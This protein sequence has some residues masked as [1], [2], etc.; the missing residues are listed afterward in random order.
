MTT[1]FLC[2]ID[3]S[4]LYK[5][6]PIGEDP[7]L[8]ENGASTSRLVEPIS[9]EETTRPYEQGDRQSAAKSWR[10]LEAQHGG[11]GIMVLTIH[12]RNNTALGP[13]RE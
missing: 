3:V 7:G 12:S 6:V 2:L 4:L 1:R 10:A 9:T 13:F 8:I 11:K 5:P